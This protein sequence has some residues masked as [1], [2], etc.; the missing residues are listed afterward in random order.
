MTVRYAA[1]KR[2]PG[3][4]PHDLVWRVFQ[5]LLLNLDDRGEQFT[6]DNEQIVI[7]LHADQAI[8]KIVKVVAA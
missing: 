5:E 2:L 3:M 8:A 7:E 1:I 6:G 4:H